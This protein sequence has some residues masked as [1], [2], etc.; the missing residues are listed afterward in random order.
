MK[1]LDDTTHQNALKQQQS[2]P[3]SRNRKVAER[4]FVLQKRGTFCRGAHQ[5][6][7]DIF[8]GDRTYN[9]LRYLLTLLNADKGRYLTSAKEYDTDETSVIADRDVNRLKKEKHVQLEASN[10][11]NQPS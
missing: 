2:Y 11:E 10:D 8:V 7:D 1:V 3:V 4:D 6:L 5:I 9:R